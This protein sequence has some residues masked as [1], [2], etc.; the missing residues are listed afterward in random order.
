VKEGSEGGVDFFV[1]SPH[2]ALQYGACF[3]KI[4]RMDFEQEIIN[5]F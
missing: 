2:E 1:K 5:Y 4:G 3:V